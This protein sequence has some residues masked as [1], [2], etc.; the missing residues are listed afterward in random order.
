MALSLL[1]KKKNLI[2]IEVTLYSEPLANVIF[3]YDTRSPAGT[4]E[5]GVQARTGRRL[6]QYSQ[7][8]LTPRGDE[9][10]RP[11]KPRMYPEAS[12][13]VKILPF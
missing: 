13:I 4:Q 6:S 11:S 9:V 7:G 8:H 3:F 2:E 1:Q 10:L 12:L 5:A